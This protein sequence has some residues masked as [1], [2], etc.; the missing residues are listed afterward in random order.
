[1]PAGQRFRARPV[2]GRVY[3]D[4]SLI[5]AGSEGFAIRFLPPHV[6]QRVAA[7][8]ATLVHGEDRYGHF[9]LEPAPAHD[10]APEAVAYHQKVRDR[11]VAILMRDAAG[12]SRA[13]HTASAM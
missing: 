4:A 1:M 9:E 13:V 10:L 2:Q 12:S 7:D 6:E 8:S 11:R 3:P 5:R